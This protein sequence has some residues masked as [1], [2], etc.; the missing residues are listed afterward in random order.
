M[1]S[2]LSVYAYSDF[3]QYLKDFFDQEKKRDPKFSHRYFAGRLGLAAS[4]FILLV[5]QGKRNI[6]QAT[7]FKIS[8]ALGHNPDE[9]AYFENLV[10][11]GQ[12][13]ALREKDAF[14]CRLVA[15]RRQM[16]IAKIEDSQYEYYSRWYHPVVRELLI[17]DD[18]N[19][20][21]RRLSESLSPSVPVREVR[22]SVDLLLRLG[23]IRKHG[24]RYVQSSPFVSTNGDVTSVAVA[25]FHRAMAGL[26]A[27]AVDRYKREDRN[28]SSCTIRISKKGYQKLTEKIACFRREV[29]SVVDSDAS[30]DRVCQMN[31]QLFP[32]TRLNQKERR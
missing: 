2:P 15:S 25:N 32:L 30:P 22:K 10:N 27:E 9:A 17:Q 18:F 5:I 20:D 13:K 12:A 11:Y 21:L 23:L 29:L 26:A 6:T 19:D 7:C 14:Y 3:R 4:N 8:G 28:L 1:K 31:F 24:G 16:K